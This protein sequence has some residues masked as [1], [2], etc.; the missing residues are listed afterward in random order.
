MFI[1]K[2]LRQSSTSDIIKT[3]YKALCESILNYCITTW[4]GASKTNLLLIE[5]SQ[6]ALLK[7][8]YYKPRLYPTTKI[9]ELSQVLTVRQLFVL[10]ITSKQHSSTIFTPGVCRRNCNIVPT[11]LNKTFFSHRFY[12]FLG[13]H[14][15]NHLNKLLSLYKLN[16]NTLKSIVT[17]WLLNQSYTSVEKLLEIPR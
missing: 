2:Q 13:P 14:I 4:G 16:K 17:N 3:V 6:R 9:Y 12:V 1:F 15:Y 11:T 8:C 7:V 10:A 5:R